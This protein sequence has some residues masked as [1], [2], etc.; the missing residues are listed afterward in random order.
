MDTFAFFLIIH[1][2]HWLSHVRLTATPW[3]VAL[4]APPS[5]GFSRQ[6]YWSGLLFDNGQVFK[7]HMCA[8]IYIQKFPEI[9]IIGVRILK[10]LHLSSRDDEHQRSYLIT[11]FEK[12][13]IC[14]ANFSCHRPL[15]SRIFTSVSK[16]W[17]LRILWFQITVGVFIPCGIEQDCNHFILR[18][19]SCTIFISVYISSTYFFSVTSVV[20]LLQTVI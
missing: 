15:Q 3:M 8:C 9:I 12:A 14:W 13:V 4:Q 1:I 6:E 20:I 7:W 2:H 17:W 18:L 10:R 16:S 11:T 19:Q 5:M